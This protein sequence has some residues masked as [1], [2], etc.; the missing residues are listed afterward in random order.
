MVLKQRLYDNAVNRFRSFAQNP[1]HREVLCQI[2]TY[3]SFLYN[4]VRTH[5]YKS[6]L[7]ATMWNQELRADGKGIQALDTQVNC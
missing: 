4:T 2:I 7:G 6:L 5:V 1:E 3:D